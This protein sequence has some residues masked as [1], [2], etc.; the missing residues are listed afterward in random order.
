L[1]RPDAFAP[2]RQKREKAQALIV[3][4]IDVLGGIALDPDAN[5]KHRID[6][7]KALDQLA[8]NGPENTPTAEHFQIIINLDG[9]T[10][11][12]VDKNLGVVSD[13]KVIDHEL[14]AASKDE[15]EPW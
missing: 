13:T 15:P 3:E 11:L 8:G 2:G 12:K 10:R 7:S 4:A 1:R 14:P 9:D 5:A 6:A